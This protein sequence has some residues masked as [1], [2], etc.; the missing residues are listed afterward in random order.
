MFRCHTLV[1]R[2]IYT[3]MFNQ[4][5]APS[6][7]APGRRVYAIGDVHGCADQLFE[8]HGLI[9][10][11]L[12]DHPCP[13]PLLVHLGDYID[14][15]P[16]SAEIIARLSLG[17]PV[18]GLPML[19]LMGNHEWMMLRA[20]A[21]SDEEDVRHWLINGGDASLKSWGIPRKAPPARWGD[22]VPKDDLAFLRDLKPYCLVDGYVF[23]H[24]G[25]LP[26]IPLAEQRWHDLLWIR[27]GFLDWDGPL[28]PEAPGVAAVHGHTPSPEP[29][30]CANRIGVDTGAVRGGKLTCAVLEGDQVGFLAV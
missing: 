26:G 6:T 7:L 14:R 13:E 16:A 24:A 30:V 15:G 2:V 10:R 23:V 3:V 25:L 12:A 4:Q 17:S 19:N 9:A 22:L 27:E 11:H 5:L 29:E 18:R 20:F 1:R 8:L 28:L 21:L